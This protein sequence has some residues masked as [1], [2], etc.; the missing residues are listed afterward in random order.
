M[1]KIFLIGPM[2]GMQKK[3]SLSWREKVKQKLSSNFIVFHA[4][5]GREEK[6]TFPDPKAAV[7][8]DKQDVLSADIILLNDTVKGM[9]MIGTAMEVQLAH[10]HHKTII[11]FGE[12][13]RGDYWLDYHITC[14][15]SSLEEAYNLLNTLYKE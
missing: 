5:R 3:D 2:R 1:K 12:A 4:M 8:R 15:V 6:E 13:H 10:I 9:S 7:V 11:A 14:R